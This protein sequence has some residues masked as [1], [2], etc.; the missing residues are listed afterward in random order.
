MNKPSVGYR[1]HEWAAEN[2]KG[3]Q[4]PEVNAENAPKQP[5][6]KNDMH[7]TTRG[8][9]LLF[10]AVVLPICAIALFFIGLVF[11]SIFTA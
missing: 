8:W 2:F 6:F 9:L 10:A 3:V 11:W 4:Y 5:F 7:W 1:I